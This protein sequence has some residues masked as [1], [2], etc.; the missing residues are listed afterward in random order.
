M[1]TISAEN[2]SNIHIKSDTYFFASLLRI[3][4]LSISMNDDTNAN[5]A[6]I[7][8]IQLL[9]TNCSSRLKVDEVKR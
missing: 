2:Q 5:P 3:L 7:S 9:N 8:I 1:Y 4:S 6:L